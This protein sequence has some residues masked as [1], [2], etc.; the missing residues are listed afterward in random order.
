M[1]EGLI[2]V[3]AR[4][5]A[6]VAGESAPRG[7]TALPEKFLIDTFA[8]AL[9]RE[10]SPLATVD[11]LQ[12]SLRTVRLRAALVTSDNVILSEIERE[13]QDDYGLAVE[14][15]TIDETTGPGGADILQQVD[16]VCSTV[17]YATQMQATANS[18]RKPFL[19]I[20]TRKAMEDM[21]WPILLRR[22]LWVIVA[23][24]A[25]GDL[26]RD[27][28]S[29]VP[30]RHNLRIVV[31]GLEDVASIPEGAPTI[32]SHRLR[33]ELRNFDFKGR[34][35]SSSRIMTVDTARRVLAFVISTNVRAWRGMQRQ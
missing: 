31:F 7:D 35:L 10:V 15:L 8:D 13:L 2:V 30:G 14:G 18:S 24:P 29:G 12:R 27:A 32:V 6:Y 28:L 16:V 23:S 1:D 33:N 22:P 17:E 34:I 11:W 20:E 3:R 19:L 26:L 25:I 9:L 4:G 5:G 21:D